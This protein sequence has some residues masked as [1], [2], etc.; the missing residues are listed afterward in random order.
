[1]SL[2]VL[3]YFASGPPPAHAAPPPPSVSC[4]LPAVA[5][6]PLKVKPQCLTC[7]LRVNLSKTANANILTRRDL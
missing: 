4:Q 1:M 2:Y 6:A 3:Y 7:Q 5:I